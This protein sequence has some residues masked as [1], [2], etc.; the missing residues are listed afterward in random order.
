MYPLTIK[1]D[2]RNNVTKTKRFEMGGSRCSRCS[3][4]TAFETGG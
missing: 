2:N 3:I 1:D 4:C